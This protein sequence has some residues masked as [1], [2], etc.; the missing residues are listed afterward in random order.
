MGCR[1]ITAAL[2]YGTMEKGR[3]S[4]VVELLLSK[5]VDISEAEEL[6][7]RITELVWDEREE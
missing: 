3:H 5:G 4:G 7:L 2:F 1:D 6:F